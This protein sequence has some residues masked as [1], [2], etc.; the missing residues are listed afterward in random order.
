MKK[1]VYGT[2]E[3]DILIGY[4]VQKGSNIYFHLCNQFGKD[5]IDKMME[6]G[7]WIGRLESQKFT[8]L[9]HDNIRFKRP[10]TALDKES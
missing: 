5:E 8:Y 4:E 7:I 9:T 6:E 1:M 2:G 3:G 10:A